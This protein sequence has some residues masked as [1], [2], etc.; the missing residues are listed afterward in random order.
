MYN[1]HEQDGKVCASSNR[2]SVSAPHF[3]GAIQRCHN[4]SVGC[5]WSNQAFE[6]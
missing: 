4:L 2:D 6:L 5:A 1:H 3:N